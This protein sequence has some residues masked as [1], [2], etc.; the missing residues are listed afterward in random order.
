M[1]TPATV[2]H[3]RVRRHTT[4]LIGLDLR[5]TSAPQRSST[6]CPSALATS[7]ANGGSWSTGCWSSRRPLGSRPASFP[8][9]LADSLPP[10]TS[11]SAPRST[12]TT[13]CWPSTPA[14]PTRAF[15]LTSSSLLRLARA[16]CHNINNNNNAVTSP[17][18]SFPI[19]DLLFRIIYWLFQFSYN[20][21]CFIDTL[22]VNYFVV[23]RDSLNYADKVIQA[24]GTEQRRELNYFASKTSTNIAKS[25]SRVCIIQVISTLLLLISI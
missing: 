2:G 18:S 22:L 19:F 17:P 13:G 12:S 7:M 9:R 15:L 6:P 24:N 23:K 4:F 16:M 10:A 5:A 11:P 8:I 20:W 14:T 25:R 21:R 3:P 1:T